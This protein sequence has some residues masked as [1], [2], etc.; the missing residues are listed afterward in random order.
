MGNKKEVVLA[1]EPTV[2]VK[3]AN[4]EKLEES[5]LIVTLP[6]I[7]ALTEDVL[8]KYLAAHNGK[9]EN[10]KKK[11]YAARDALSTRNLELI[12]NGVLSDAEKTQITVDL[13]KLAAGATL[14]EVLE[15]K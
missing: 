7:G 2:D 9:L 12:L 5:T 8:L 1:A 13:L 14:K 3:I 10:Q 15:A 6:P 4:R 11:V